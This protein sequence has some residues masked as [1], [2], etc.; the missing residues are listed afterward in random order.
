MRRRIL[1]GLLALGT[2]GGY[3]MGFS[4]L[5]HRAAWRRDRFER[6]VAAVCVD[7]ARLDKDAR[8]RAVEAEP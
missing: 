5:R 3:A 1:I 6:H 2:V 8:A 4:C 7:A